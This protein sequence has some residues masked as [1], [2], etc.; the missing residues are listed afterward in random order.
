MNIVDIIIIAVL[1]SGGLTGFH[2]GFFKQSLILFGTIIIFVVSWYFKDYIADFLSFF[3]PFFKFG[4]LTSLNIVLYQLMAFL[5]ILAFLAAVLIVLIKITGIFEKV[6]KFTI[7]LGIPSKI[8]GFFVGLLESYIILFVILFFLNQPAFSFNFMKDSSYSSFII[9][10]S[11][12]L[13]DVVGDMNNS[14]KEI[15]KITKDYKGNKNAKKTNK[16]IIKSLLK[17][18]VVDQK[19]L[20]KLEKKGKIKY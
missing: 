4:G 19:Y 10:S 14:V 12:I 3:L 9:H 15:Y 18:D 11:P 7:V 20:D 17:Y 16:K 1:L 2:N 5:L 13:S 6:L 8:L